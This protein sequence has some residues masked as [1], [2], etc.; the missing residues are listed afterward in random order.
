VGD[1]IVY[2]DGAYPSPPGTSPQLAASDE[3]WMGKI[4]HHDITK[5]Q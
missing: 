2:V 4:D 1:T 3:C 5:I